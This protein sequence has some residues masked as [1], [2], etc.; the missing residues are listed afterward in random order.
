[1]K[2]L[3]YRIDMDNAIIYLTKQL[4]EKIVFKS[5]DSIKNKNKFHLKK[6]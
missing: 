1:M 6:K 2:Y 5:M 4:N 3:N